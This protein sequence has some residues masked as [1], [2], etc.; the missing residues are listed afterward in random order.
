MP[1]FTV[2]KCKLRLDGS[3]LNEVPQTDVTAAE[4]EMLRGL[5][6]SDAVLDIKE[7]GTIERTDAA[8]RAAVKNKYLHPLDAPQ[9]LKTKTQIFRD[10]FGHDSLPMPR[11]LATPE[12]ESE[13]EPVEETKP[14]RRSR[15][16]PAFAE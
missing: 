8:E 2:Y 13:V 6:G 1:T 7:T 15:A 14:I 12:P 11:S 9:R 5:H 3:V 4:I 16:Q 10:A